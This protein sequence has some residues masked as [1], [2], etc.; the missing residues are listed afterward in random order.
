MDSERS[1]GLIGR[2][3]FVTRAHAALQ[4]ACWGGCGAMNPPV[5]RP[6]AQLTAEPEPVM[7]QAVRY[8]DRAGIWD[9]RPF[10]FLRAAAVAALL[11]ARPLFAAA[12]GRRARR[13]CANR[14][15]CAA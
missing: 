10:G 3:F 2:G 1:R 8:Y 6:A 4:T 7:K 15:P 13:R 9:V 14:R 12:T 11:A 5:R